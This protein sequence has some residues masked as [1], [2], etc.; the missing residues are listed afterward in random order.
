MLV[1]V[2]APKKKNRNKKIISDFIEIIC[3][4]DTFMLLKS[5]NRYILY[6]M[7]CLTK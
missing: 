5:E 3:Y 2:W 6:Y 4:A 1:K 7:D